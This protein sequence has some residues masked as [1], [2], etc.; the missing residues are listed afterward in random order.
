MKKSIIFRGLAVALVAV[1]ALALSVPARASNLF[2]K[3]ITVESGVTIY[4]DGIELIPTDAGGNH[5]ET[6]VYNG[7]TYVP[8]RAVSE[9]FNKPVNWDGATSSVYIG[10]VPGQ[11]LYLSDV[12]PAYQTNKAKTYDYVTLAGNKYL[13]NIVFDAKYGWALYNL[14]GQFSTLE[15]DVGHV[16]G[17]DMYDATIN[18]YLDGKLAYTKDLSAQDL[19]EHVLVALNGAL[20]MKIEFIQEDLSSWNGPYYYYA[21]VNATIK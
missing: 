4:V 20:Q 6:F 8:I 10:K 16:D 11:Q 12:C 15:F 3:N 2:T 18:V 14:N 17:E 5:V 1:T 13:D 21:I 19:P 9:A 7:T